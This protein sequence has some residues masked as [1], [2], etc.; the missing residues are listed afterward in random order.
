M[1]KQNDRKARD[2][3]KARTEGMDAAARGATREACP[4]HSRIEYREAWIKGF[5]AELAAAR[6]IEREVMKF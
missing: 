4:Y 5:E 3:R 2:L 6:G 1:G